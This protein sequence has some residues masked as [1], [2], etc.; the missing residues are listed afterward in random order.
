[1]NILKDKKQRYIL[2]LKLQTELYE[3]D[4]LNKRFEIGRQLYNSVLGKSFK[5]YQ[6]MIKTIK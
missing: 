2:T 3:E 1:M 5:R 6:E 4:I